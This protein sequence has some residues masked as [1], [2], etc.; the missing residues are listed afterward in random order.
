MSA[1]I[2][3]SQHIW[4]RNYFSGEPSCRMAGLSPDRKQ[5]CS[6]R[7]PQLM[8]SPRVNLLGSLG[9]TDTT[10]VEKTKDVRMSPLVPLPV[11]QREILFPK[12]NSHIAVSLPSAPPPPTWNCPRLRHTAHA[13]KRESAKGHSHPCPL[14]PP[15]CCQIQ[16][17]GQ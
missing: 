15:M 9:P 11:S 12:E 13:W 14:Q 16:E 8:G 17:G 7:V 2:P 4:Q 3:D 1:G 6:T 5:C 10:D